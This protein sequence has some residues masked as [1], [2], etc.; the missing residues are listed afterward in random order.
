MGQAHRVFVLILI[1]LSNFSDR[2][3]KTRASKLRIQVKFLTNYS[4][5]KLDQGAREKSS[6]IIIPATLQKPFLL[7]CYEMEPSEIHRVPPTDIGPSRA[8]SIEAIFCTGPSKGAIF[9][10]HGIVKIVS[11]HRMIFCKD[12]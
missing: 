10:V 4:I 7:F 5:D 12:S 11:K 6:N 9:F 1:I 3:A 8:L 2:A